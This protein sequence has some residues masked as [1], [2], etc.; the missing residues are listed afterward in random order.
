MTSAI[1]CNC[2]TRD[3]SRRGTQCHYPPPLNETPTYDVRDGGQ[4][5]CTHCLT[6]TPYC[7]ETRH[8]RVAGGHQGRQATSS[9]GNPLA[10]Y[11]KDPDGQ[12]VPVIIYKTVREA[13]GRRRHPNLPGLIFIFSAIVPTLGPSTCSTNPAWSTHTTARIT[14]FY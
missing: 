4:R 6:S 11:G 1:Y 8:R 7:G 9:T 13:R 12:V 10:Q 2:W 3:R 14:P 5:V